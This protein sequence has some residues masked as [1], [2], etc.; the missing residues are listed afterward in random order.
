MDA[1]ALSL[2]AAN[3]NTERALND[4]HRPRLRLPP[5]VYFQGGAREHEPD[6]PD[7]S[8]DEQPD[9]AVSA[10][11]AEQ[12]P[13][14]VSPRVTVPPPPSEVVSRSHLVV[15]VG[16]LLIALTV[17]TCYLPRAERVSRGS[18]LRDRTNEN[19]ARVLQPFLVS[20]RR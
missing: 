11:L 8:S 19:I 14:V 12:A 5:R 4:R 6:E 1:E 15:L 20:P 16:V 17:S 7:E 9:T 13:L 18:D 2:A 3:R 10:R